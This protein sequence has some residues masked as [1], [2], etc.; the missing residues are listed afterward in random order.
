MELQGLRE[1]IR[2]LP[3]DNFNITTANVLP[4]KSG[5]LDVGTV[6]KVTTIHH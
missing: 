2:Q 5:E 4:S 6:E 1:R 3:V